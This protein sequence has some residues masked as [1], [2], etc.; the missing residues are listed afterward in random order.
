MSIL[1]HFPQR[2]LKESLY[3]DAQ[4]QSVETLRGIRVLTLNKNGVIIRLHGVH[5]RRWIAE[6]RQQLAQDFSE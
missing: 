5:A 3:P 2:F 6:H 1:P 4:F